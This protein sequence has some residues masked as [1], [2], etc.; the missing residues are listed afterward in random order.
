[1]TWRDIR[2]TR[3]RN[4]RWDTTHGFAGIFRDAGDEAGA[5]A[6]AGGTGR[7]GIEPRGDHQPT[8]GGSVVAAQDPLG[9]HL[10]N[11]VDEQVP[12]QWDPKDASVVVGVVSNTRDG[13]LATDF[14]DEAFFPMTAANEQPVMYL[15]LRTR[16]TRRQRRRDCGRQWRRSIRRYR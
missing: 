14:G 9:R 3:E 2:A 16:E 10:M 6:A 8:H 7:I 15:L 13:S 11:V 4:R 1:M 5:G 12:L